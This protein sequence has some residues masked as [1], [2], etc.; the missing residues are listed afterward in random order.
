MDSGW[1]KSSFSGSN[2]ENCVE[3]RISSS[4]VAL[5][6]SKNPL[7]TFTIS[8]ASWRFFLAAQQSAGEPRRH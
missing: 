5:R 6:D 3:V 8:T 2:N 4:S 1:F 7:P